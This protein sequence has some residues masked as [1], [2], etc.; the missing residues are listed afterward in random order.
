VGRQLCKL[1]GVGAKRKASRRGSGAKNEDKEDG[2]GC[3]LGGS[4]RE[5]EARLEAGS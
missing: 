5:F 4:G 2:F 1:N 3:S